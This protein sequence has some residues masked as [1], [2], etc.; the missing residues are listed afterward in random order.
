MQSQSHFEFAINSDI[1]SCIIYYYVLSFRHSAHYVSFH[2]FACP[3][4]HPI[5]SFIYP[6]EPTFVPICH[7]SFVYRSQ[8]GEVHCTFWVGWSVRMEGWDA[9]KG[10]SFLQC[11][12]MVI[13]R[14]RSIYKRCRSFGFPAKKI[15][16]HPH[17]R[18]GGR[19]RKL[20]EDKKQ[21][22]TDLDLGGVRRLNNWKPI[23]HS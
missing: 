8:K 16:C 18:C 12:E 22:R 13:F 6:A 9:W 2:Q 1:I 11:S 23:K 7:P 3:L 4:H 14:G 5:K 21:E 20:S 19:N 17:W 10:G 15:D